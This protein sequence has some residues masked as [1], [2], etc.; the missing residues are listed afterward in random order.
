MFVKKLILKITKQEVNFIAQKF[1]RFHKKCNQ[2]TP[3]NRSSTT[4]L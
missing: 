2:I 3:Q 1:R 4:A